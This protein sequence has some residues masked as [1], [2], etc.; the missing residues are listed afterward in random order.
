MCA[1]VCVCV[2]ACV[3]IYGEQ[4]QNDVFLNDVWIMC[5]SDCPPREFVYEE[6]DSD[7][8]PLLVTTCP[9]ASSS[10]YD[11]YAYSSSYDII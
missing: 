3:C 6:K 11:V 9:Q 10:S 8:Q 1:F 4:D 7:G 5:V 2:C